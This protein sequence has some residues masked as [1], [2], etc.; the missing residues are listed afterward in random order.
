MLS[1]EQFKK[2]CGNLKELVKVQT[3]IAEQAD[4]SD[5]SIEITLKETTAQ[6]SDDNLRVL[7]MG[8]FSSGKSTFLNAMMGKM[9]LPA[10]PQPTTAVIGE[11]IYSEKEEA[12]LYPKDPKAKPLQV[13]I[14]DMSKYIVI[15]HENAKKDEAKKPNPYKKILIKYPLS[16]CKHG[17][18]FVD[19]PGLDDPT[20]HDTITQ[21][22]LPK[23]DA[24]IY[25]MN[26]QQCYCAYDKMEIE[27]LRALGYRSIIFVITYFDVLLSNDMMCGTNE[28]EKVRKHYTEI[29]KKL[30][31]LGESGIFFVGSLPALMGK[32][33][34]KPELLKLS[35]FP[36]FEKRLEEILFNEKGKMKLLKAIYGVRRIN[37]QIGQ[38][39]NDKIDIANSDTANLANKIHIAQNNLTQA[40]AKADA[41][42]AQFSLATAN[43]VEGAKTRFR[44]FLLNEILPNIEGW[45]QEFAPTEEQEIKLTHPKSSV[46]AF[47][48]ACTKFIQ[49]YIETKIG[50]WTTDLVE[51]YLKPNIV[52]IAKSQ[53]ANL[54][55]YENDLK[56]IRLELNLSVSGENVSEETNAGTAN[57]ILSAIG[58]FVSGGFVGSYMGGMLGWEALV[59]N[60]VAQVVTGIVIFIVSMFNPVSIPVAIGAALIASLIAGGISFSMFEDKVKKKLV[61]EL[62]EG[63]RNSQIELEN[64]IGQSVSDNINEINKA[65]R[66][67]LEAP[68]KQCQDLLDEANAT[69]NAQGDTLRKKIEVYNALRKHNSSLAENID[70]I[71]ESIGI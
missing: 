3:G 9:L 64:N 70:I 45:A 50:E 28:A 56:K 39:L 43:L 60:L 55:D 47:S 32:T 24:I 7:V 31:D 8:K 53:Q 1:P 69:V 38:M 46:V 34:N 20:C 2:A 71:A 63:I 54:N 18:M 67:G 33:N 26:V 25:C 58:G 27:R 6:L 17:I 11:I 48:E 5:K 16:V 12:V 41:I 14:E 13:K 35:N 19:S 59:T 15:D 21:E 65:A 68:V 61:N 29:L 22:Y 66:E 52:Q 10:K 30:T 36:P 57:R 62:K 23:A 42:S 40:R 4:S 44:S 49:G 37:R 51:N